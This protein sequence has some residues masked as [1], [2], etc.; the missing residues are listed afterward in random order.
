M[1]DIKEDVKYG[2]EDPNQVFS[3]QRLLPER[4]HPSN[5]LSCLLQKP[6]KNGPVSKFKYSNVS[7]LIYKVFSL[8]LSSCENKLRKTVSKIMVGICI[9]CYHCDL[10]KKLRM[11]VCGKAEPEIKVKDK[12]FENIVLETNAIIFKIKIF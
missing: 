2:K 4:F 5:T 1:I 6:D 11:M 3:T 7:T 10:Q 9:S 8:T 12:K